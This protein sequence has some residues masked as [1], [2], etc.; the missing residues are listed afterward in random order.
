MVMYVDE[1]DRIFIRNEFFCNI[2]SKSG[3]CCCWSPFCKKDGNNDDDDEEEEGTEG[4]SD[5]ISI[6]TVT[7]KRPPD[8]AHS[9]GIQLP[10]SR[11]KFNMNFHSDD[12]HGDCASLL[13]LLLS[14]SLS[15]SYDDDDKLKMVV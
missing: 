15:I 9:S 1:G 12:A 2:G 6:G 8:F 4:R 10:G 14:A 11:P 13:L 3:V 5:V 7:T